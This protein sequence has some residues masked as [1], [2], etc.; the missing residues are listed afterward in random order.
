[1]RLY[2]RITIILILSILFTACGGGSEDS[3]SIVL[4]TD[5]DGVADVSDAFP[6]D[7]TEN[8][9]TDSDGVGDNADTDDDNDGVAD[10]SDAFP[11]DTTRYFS[12]FLN[13]TNTV[14]AGYFTNISLNI[15]GIQSPTITWEIISPK[16]SYESIKDDGGNTYS[17]FV[18]AIGNY[19]FT[20]VVSDGAISEQEEIYITSTV[21]SKQGV[22]GIISTNTSWTA[23]MS[24]IVISDTL[25][26]DVGATL[27]IESGVYVYGL[28]QDILFQSWGN[29]IINGTSESPAYILGINF[30]INDLSNIDVNHSKV[31]NCRL[32]HFVD[33]GSATSIKNTDIING[34]VDLY[35]SS[36]SAFSLVDSNLFGVSMYIQQGTSGNI[37]FTN[38]NIIHDPEADYSLEGPGYGII[39]L[40]SLRNISQ[41]N[42]I[43]NNYLG[44]SGSG[45]TIYSYTHGYGGVLTDDVDISGSYWDGMESVELP[46]YLYD[47]SDDLESPAFFIYEPVLSQPDNT[48]P[49]VPQW[50]ISN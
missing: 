15:N 13:Y 41:T 35:N 50:M 21:P 17:F 48:A 19:T 30:Q 10:V 3:D 2:F 26:L 37:A 36:N 33:F 45:Y 43:G 12:V 7:A 27:T 22:S 40:R 49:V 47:R 16:G 34:N 11:L 9:D 38:N 8:I 1:M 42:F 14:E 18:D 20:V 24:P 46:I 31:V 44:F 6:L 4:D 5:N 25:Q 29:I 32:G 39:H 28:Y 23:N